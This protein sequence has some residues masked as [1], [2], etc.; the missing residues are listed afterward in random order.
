[1]PPK[2]TGP[3]QV[4]DFFATLDHPLKGAM[5]KVREIILSSDDT[6]TEQIKWKGPS[7]CYNGD[8]RVTF[9]VRDGSVLLI[10][11]RG[12]KVKDS[13]G[14]GRLIDD[15]TGLLEWITDDRAT[16]KFTSEDE[17]DLKKDDL[18]KVVRLWVGA[19]G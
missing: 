2:K 17:V 14:G 9:N 1:M 8:D 18:T 15:P 13:T 10:F 3:E 16:V 6:I 12:A 11:H 5:K 19:A 7:F 4:A